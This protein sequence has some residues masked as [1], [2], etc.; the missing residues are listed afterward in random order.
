MPDN[1]SLKGMPQPE[2]SLTYQ[3]F[4]SKVEI[5][6]I[7]IKKL[8]MNSFLTRKEVKEKNIDINLNIDFNFNQFINASTFEA[9]T[10]VSVI[11]EIPNQK[12]FSIKMEL[13]VEYEY[14]EIKQTVSKE[15][16]DNFINSNVPVNV[17]P[18]IREIIHNATIRM[19]YAP[20]IIKPFRVIM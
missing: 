20:L 18:Y 1:D 19:G 5:K 6:D 3:E 13:L 16:I 4:V 15:I 12:V 11:A 2:D 9:I 17:W 14:D 10:A 7:R 8:E